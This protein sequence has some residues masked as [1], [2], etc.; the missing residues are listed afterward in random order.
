MS[1]AA[2]QPILHLTA[3]NPHVASTIPH[4]GAFFLPRQHAP[5]SSGQAAAPADTAWGVSAFAFQG[6]NAHA[7]LAL[8]GAD[9]AAVLTLVNPRSTAW[10]KERFWIGP[11]PHAL[12]ACVARVATTA[13]A[14]G[15]AVLFEADLMQPKRAFMW[16]HAVAGR[17]ILP[18]AAFL[19]AAAGCLHTAAAAGDDGVRLLLTAVTIP[20]PLELP[21][22]AGSK[23]K[24][25]LLL[26]CQMEISSGRVRIASRSGGSSREHM[27]GTAAA[28]AVLPAQQQPRSAKTLPASGAVDLLLLAAAAGIQQ[29]HASIGSIE[30]ARQDGKVGGR[31]V[32][33]ACVDASFHLGA[34]PAGASFARPQL[35]VPAAIAA[36]QVQGSSSSDASPQ[37]VVGCQPV[38]MAQSSI[39][40]DYWLADSSC[41]AGSICRVAGLEA[42]ALG[43]LPPAAQPAVGVP[44]SAAVPSSSANQGMLYEV[45][46]VA[47]QAAAG[48]ELPAASGHTA[49]VTFASSQVDEQQLAAAGTAA[50]Q[51]SG[52]SGGALLATSGMLA[53]A[54]SAPVPPAAAVAAGLLQGL[55]KAAAQENA[56]SSY[57]VADDDAYSTRH[58]SHGLLLSGSTAAAEAADVHGTATRAGAAFLPVLMPDS[59]LGKP[60]EDLLQ[61]QGQGAVVISG[62]TGTLG[63]LI[64]A[65]LASSS[66]DRDSDSSRHVSLLGRSGRLGTSSESAALLRTAAAN[67][68]AMEIT[69]A[70]CDAAAAEDAAFAVAA[71]TSQEQLS[72]LL[73]AGGVLA[74]ALLAN[75]TVGAIRR[76][77]APK[78]ASLA[79]LQAPVQLQPA[80]K[81]MLFSS[82]AA[83][84]GSPGQANY[85]AANAAL[86]A[87]S[88]CAQ[89]QVSVCG[90]WCISQLVG[91]G[92]DT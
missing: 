72:A 78:V 10:A 81:S 75:L 66:S 67:S 20:A 70:S 8:A 56:S 39:N 30:S 90:D 65:F 1:G 58:A 71:A 42:R 3:L 32:S 24:Q 19:E 9:S 35:R 23:G 44:V 17:P 6:T 62:G 46:W 84:L 18:G 7:L 64:A 43:R 13:G 52:G 57:S 15:T 63:Q 91:A 83:L 33:P 49:T 60:A 12:V 80:V 21:S 41:G 34:L 29:Q 82:V 27:Y 54:A 53:G 16:D 47:A 4:P 87:A 68:K 76:A 74:D 2:A 26:Q 77:F 22:A 92:C 55:L 48:R 61:R 85:S 5:S 69:V 79:R 14:A 51:L 25:Q 38:S 40:N 45:A 59:G 31:G 50:L 73:H 86:D 11:E 89:Q 88:Q 37:M 28:A 36:Y